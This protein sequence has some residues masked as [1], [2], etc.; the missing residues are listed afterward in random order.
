MDHHADVDAVRKK[1]IHYLQE[2]LEN[3][4]RGKSSLQTAEG[5]VGL[6]FDHPNPLKDVFTAGTNGKLIPRTRWIADRR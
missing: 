2:L 4:W 5:I 6:A 3:T 1:A